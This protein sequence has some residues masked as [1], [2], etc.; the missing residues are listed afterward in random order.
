MESRFSTLEDDRWQEMLGEL[1][2]VNDVIDAED[3]TMDSLNERLN[4]AVFGKEIW[5][6]F[7]WIALIFLIT[8]TLVSRLYKAESIS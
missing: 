2:N 1:F 5:N 3:L 7:V 6:W 8:E 4:T